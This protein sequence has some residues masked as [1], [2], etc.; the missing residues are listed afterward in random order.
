MLLTLIVDYCWCWHKLD[1]DLKI[2]IVFDILIC[3]VVMTLCTLPKH[4]T[5]MCLLTLN[6]PYNI[7]EIILPPRCAF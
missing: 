4:A 7:K 2:E 5:T 1:F 3:S 6:N